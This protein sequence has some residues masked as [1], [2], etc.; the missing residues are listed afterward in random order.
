LFD[1]RA[2]DA[3]HGPRIAFVLRALIS[4]GMLTLRPTKLE[5]P[6]VYAHLKD[7]TVF[8]DGK[9]IGRIYELRPPTQ[10]TVAWSW[11]IT[12]LGPG[13]GHV[14]TDDRAATLGGGQGAI[15]RE[16]GGV[17]GRWAGLGFRV[18]L[19]YTQ[20]MPVEFLNGRPLSPDEL[21]QLRLEI[22]SFD[23]ISAVSDEVRGIV[24]RNSPHLLAKLPPDPDE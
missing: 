13:R 23:D 11:S 1:E 6:P 19:I 10:P 4:S 12:T 21:D 17:Q 9:E 16:L 7:Y 5:S 8:E 20:A 14:K 15:C 24:K 22:E 2:A 18:G 3:L